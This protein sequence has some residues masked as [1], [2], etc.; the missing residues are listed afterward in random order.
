MTPDGATLP[1]WL[2]H[3]GSKK[4]KSDPIV[5]VDGADP[6]S[7]AHGSTYAGSTVSVTVP[8]YARHTELGAT[9]VAEL[10]LTYALNK[11][12]GHTI[13]HSL[14][15][16][17]DGVTTGYPCMMGLE[18][19]IFDRYMALGATG[20]AADMTDND[21]TNH[22]NTNQQAIYAWDNDGYQA[23]VMYI[24]DLAATVENWV[25]SP[26]NQLYWQDKVDNNKAYAKRFESSEAFDNTTVWTSEC[27]YRVQWF[28][29]GAAA[30]MSP[31]AS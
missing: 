5:L 7:L 13:S 3:T 21:G 18:Q 8:A 1:E 6:G 11:A 9:N 2:G 19:T 27:N 20:P 17:M 22:F 10:T 24:P 14:A 31:F 12:T 30:V 28:P 23:A 26:T 25:K 29:D 16:S 15:W 4:Y